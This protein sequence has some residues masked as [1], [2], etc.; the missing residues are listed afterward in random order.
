MASIGLGLRIVF[1]G[2]MVLL[3]VL[4]PYVLIPLVA[5][6]GFNVV[7]M[8]LE[9]YVVFPSSVSYEIYLVLN[10]LTSFFGC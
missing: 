3:V 6:P 7:F 4:V 8:F 10:I 9:A 5:V 2:L 1:I